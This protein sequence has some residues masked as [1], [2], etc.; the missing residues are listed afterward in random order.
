MR[1]AVA[2]YLSC[3]FLDANALC[4]SSMMQLGGM[5][6]SIKLPRWGDPDVLA[7]GPRNG[8]VIEDRLSGALGGS[9]LGR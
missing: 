2:T 3:R 9:S 1:T 4:S 7:R 5:G 6:G 8:R